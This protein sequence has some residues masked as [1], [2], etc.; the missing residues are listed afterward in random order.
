MGSKDRRLCYSIAFKVEVVNYA[1][2]HG[3]E[4]SSEN[5]RED[6]FSGS[7]DDFLGFYDE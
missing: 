3:S 6:D 4:A 5:S 2:K 1:E 7:D